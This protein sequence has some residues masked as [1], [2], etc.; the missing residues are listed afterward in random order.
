MVH[1][2]SVTAYPSRKHSGVMNTSMA[3]LRWRLNWSSKTAKF[4]S[5]SHF[6]GIAL[7]IPMVTARLLRFIS[8]LPDTSLLS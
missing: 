1:F 4:P 3:S 6:F 8:A 2:F 5:M 7:K